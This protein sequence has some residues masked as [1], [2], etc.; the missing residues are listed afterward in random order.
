MKLWNQIGAVLV[1]LWLWIIFLLVIG[2]GYSYFWCSGTIIYLLMRRKVDDAEIDEIYMEEEEQ[3]RCR[4]LRHRPQH[5]RRRQHRCK[6]L[7]RPHCGL[8]RRTR[9]RKLRR[10]RVAMETNPKG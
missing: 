4:G 8:R 1:A 2:F 10:P 3:P 6:W 5:R 7:M 9:L